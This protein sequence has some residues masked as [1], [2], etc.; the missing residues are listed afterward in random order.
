MWKQI[1]N[2]NYRI[3]K[4]AGQSAEVMDDNIQGGF[5]KVKIAKVKAQPEK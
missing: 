2:T 5:G 4:Q 1:R 3:Y